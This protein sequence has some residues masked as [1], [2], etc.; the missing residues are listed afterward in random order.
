M[1]TT[2]ETI[3]LSLTG[4]VLGV[5]AGG[6]CVQYFGHFGINLASLAEGLSAMGYSTKVYPQAAI[7]FFLSVTVIVIFTAILS[8]IYPARKALKLNPSQAIRME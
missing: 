1:D 8:S 3:F 4:G 7:P 2:L 5:L 6:I